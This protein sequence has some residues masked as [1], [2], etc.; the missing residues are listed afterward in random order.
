[1]SYSGSDAPGSPHISGQR[2]LGKIGGASVPSSR[3]S[4]VHDDPR[5]MHVMMGL[6]THL[7]LD[8]LREMSTL[9]GARARSGSVDSDGS[10]GASANAI[11]GPS[12]MRV[13][14]LAHGHHKKKAK[15]VSALVNAESTDRDQHPYLSDSDDEGL[16]SPRREP[17]AARDSDDPPRTEGRLLIVANRLPLSMK[18]TKNTDSDGRHYNE[19]TFS[20]SSGGLVSALKGCEMESTWIGW[21]GAEIRRAADREAV[22]NKL[23]EQNCVPVFIPQ[24]VCEM[25]YNGFCNN[26][27]W[28]LF[29]YLPM[30]IESITTA[31]SQFDAYTIANQAFADVTLRE[32]EE[33]DVVWVHDYHALLLPQMMRKKHANMR[34]GFFFHTPFPAFEFYRVLPARKELLAG[35]LGADLIGF[36]TPDYQR[37]FQDACVRILGATADGDTVTYDGFTSTLGA[38]PIGIEPNRLI[39]SINSART[40]RYVQQYRKDFKGKKVLLGIDRLDYIKGIPHKIMAL[41]RLFQT[42]PEMSKEVIMVQIA[43]PSRTDVEAYVDHMSDV[44][45]LVSRVNGQYGG[46]TSTPIHYL[47]QSIEFDRMCAL[48][49]VADAMVVTSVRDG[50]NLVAYE[51]IACQ[52]DMPGTLILSEFAGAAQTLSGGP[53]VVNPWAITSVSDAMYQALVMPECERRSRCAAMFAHVTTHTSSAWARQFLTAVLDTTNT[54]V[55]WLKDLAKLA[56]KEKEK[57][58]ASATDGA[59]DTLTAPTKDARVQ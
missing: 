40:E 53:L 23:H 12:S 24:N 39:N 31:A 58:Q 9:G 36:H 27:L 16:D 25:Y 33:G 44:H 13:A 56:E 19:M 15:P 46:V 41:E 14:L 7:S 35:V 59:A 2:S 55:S 28:P 3:V 4:G 50:M 43:V 20:H 30:S 26:L 22:R 38:F 57:A 47:D 5:H 6:G 48:Y 54:P 17:K 42:H 8:E 37:H 29:H 32:Y 1:M 34:I 49:R 45:K 21:P 51:Y 18:V 10:G 52:Q 11:V